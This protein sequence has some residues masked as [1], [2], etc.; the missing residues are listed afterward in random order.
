MQPKNRFVLLFQRI[1][2]ILAFYS[3]CR[4]LFLAFN[5]SYYK[6]ESVVAI[7]SCFFFGLRFDITA[8]VIS[9]L[10][11]IALSVLPLPFFYHRIYQA[12]LKIIFILI[13]SVALFF[14]CADFE[15]FKFQGKRATGDLFRIMSFGDDMTNI[16]PRTLLDYWYVLIVLFAL[17]YF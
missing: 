10:L 7:I 2:L 5:F 1:L 4:L 12:I 16:L 17:L 13:N 14:N 9:N 15:L 11:F 8:I 6:E 3:L